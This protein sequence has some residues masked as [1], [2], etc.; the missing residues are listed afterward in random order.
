MG[1]GERG[2]GRGEKGEAG[3]KPEFEVRG[4]VLLL[5]ACGGSSFQL[6]FLTTNEFV[7]VCVCVC[8]HLDMN[9]IILFKIF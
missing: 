5:V 7:C 6:S 1:R 8:V 9:K 3:T 2:E 4:A